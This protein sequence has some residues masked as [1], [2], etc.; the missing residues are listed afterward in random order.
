MSFT[1]YARRARDPD[2]SPWQRLSSLRAC[3]TSFCW[4]TRSP[5]RDTLE[6]LGLTWTRA[7]PRDPPTDAFLRR[8]LDRLERERNLYLGSLRGWETRRVRAKMR[9]G[10]H[11]SRADAEVREGLRQRAQAGLAPV[12]PS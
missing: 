10:R 3:V 4:L 11:L 12:P 1:Y 9:G 8:T 5:Y 7:I 6:R 2:R